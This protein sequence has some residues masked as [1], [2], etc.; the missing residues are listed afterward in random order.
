MIRCYTP[1]FAIFYAKYEKKTSTKMYPRE[2]VGG[3]SREYV[4]RIP[5]V[6]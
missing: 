3:L 6:S 5:G 2:D 4:L 1:N